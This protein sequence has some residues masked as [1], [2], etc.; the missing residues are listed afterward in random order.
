M[1]SPPST[2]IVLQSYASFTNSSNNK[3][4][5]VGSPER[6]SV[7]AVSAL[8]VKP[9][10]NPVLEKS[11][12]ELALLIMKQKDRNVDKFS[13]SPNECSAVVGFKPFEGSINSR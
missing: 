7:S 4:G 12:D 13:N 1:S 5:Q 9:T 6:T 8:Q 3:N 2:G 10:V 11:A